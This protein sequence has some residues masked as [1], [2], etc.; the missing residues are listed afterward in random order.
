[1]STATITPS[2]ELEELGK[3]FTLA[4]RLL[5]SDQAAPQMFSTAID[6][7]WHQLVNDPAAHDAFAIQHA[8]RKLAHTDDGGIGFISW[9]SVYEEAYGPLPEIW[10]T[11]AEG[12]VNTEA[13]ARYRETGEVWGEWDCSPAPTEGDDL[14]P[15]ATTR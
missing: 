6:A 14:A 3:F 7:A 11:D 13:L 8:G 9:V 1:M 15:T 12:T 5:D 10:F 2:V 4:A